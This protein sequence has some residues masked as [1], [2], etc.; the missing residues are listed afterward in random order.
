M[1]HALVPHAALLPGTEAGC[2]ERGR[3][4]ALSGALGVS[5]LPGLRV[6]PRLRR[7]SSLAPR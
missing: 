7:V 2:A 6:P 1:L 5:E 4:N 3:G